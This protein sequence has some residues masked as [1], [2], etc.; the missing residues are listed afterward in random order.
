MCGSPIDFVTVHVTVSPWATTI[1]GGS[2]RLSAMLTPIVAP[3]TGEIAAAAMSSSG[4]HQ[5][6]APGPVHERHPQ[7]LR[8]AS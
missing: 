5:A 8:T 7:N 2:N 3:R 1:L 4:G 6:E